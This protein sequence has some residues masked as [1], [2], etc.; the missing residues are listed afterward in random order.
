MPTDQMHRIEVDNEVYDQIQLE[1]LRYASDDSENAAL[2]R[3]LKLFR[4]WRYGK[5]VLPHGTRVRM[6]YNHRSYF[7]EIYDGG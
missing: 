7:G 1:K 6:T 2:R 5:L 3:L 4:P